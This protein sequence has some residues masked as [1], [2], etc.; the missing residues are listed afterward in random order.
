[1]SDKHDH[2]FSAAIPTGDAD[3]PQA[4]GKQAAVDGYNTYAVRV[5]GRVQG[6]NFRRFVQE[7]ADSL[8]VCGWVRN[9]PDG[10]VRAVLQSPETRLI[11]RV[12]EQLHSGPPAAQVDEVYVEQLADEPECGAFEI[13]HS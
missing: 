2:D 9:E 11:E 1:M 4:D 3:Y 8:R 7:L 10:S 5:T 13:R 6:V 12:I